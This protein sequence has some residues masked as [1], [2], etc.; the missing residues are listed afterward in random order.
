MS[1]LPDQDGLVCVADLGELA[2]AG[3]RIVKLGA[4]QIL[5]VHSD[6]GVFACNNRC[7][8]E[9]YPLMEGTLT[10]GCVLTCNWHNWKFHLGTGET[11]VGGDRLRHYPTRVAAGQVW[12]DPADPPAAERIEQA[13]DNL[14]AAMPRHEYDRMAREIARLQA[15]GGDPLAAV[16]RALAATHDAYEFGM[17]HA[18]AAAAD[19]LALR[20]S[21]AGTD[22]ARRLAPILEIVGHLAWDTRREPRHPF[23]AGAEAWE[24]EALVAAIEAEDEAR[25]TRLVRGALQAGLDTETLTRP[26]A[27]AALAHYQDFGHALIYVAKT[28]ELIRRLGRQAAEPALL[29]LVRALVYARREDL[30]PEFRAY[31]PAGAAWDGRGDALPRVDDLAR[32]SVGRALDLT[33]AGSAK[34][35]ALYDRLLH[36]AARQWLHFDLD[37]QDRVDQPIS[38]NVGWLDFTHMLTF[39]NAVRTLAT[40][41]PDLWPAGLLQLA[42]FLGRNAPFCDFEQD[43]SRWRVADPAAFLAER[44]T[45]LFDHGAPEYIVSS[46]LVKITLALTAEIEAAPEAP[47]TADLLAA[48]NRFFA[49]PLK[50]KHV[51][52]SATQAIAFVAAEG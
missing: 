24:P 17:G 26:L 1:A 42:C 5:L 49:S 23:A 27:R 39:A 41:F 10:E 51:A 28:A 46:H 47:W 36:A 31:G 3:R 34:P 11:L 4:K 35:A 15:A 25:A 30:I 9:G 21:D 6:R 45:A 16:R 48:A 44:T 43:Q 37:L 29:A 2:R 7:P 52:R 20:A 8:H 14:I 50:R 33:V 22:P 19:W 32:A 13:L 18:Q 40:R 38:R 12:L